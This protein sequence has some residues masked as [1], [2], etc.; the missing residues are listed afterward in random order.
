M[1]QILNNQIQCE[2]LVD[3]INNY[4]FLDDLKEAIDEYMFDNKQRTI[5]NG[6]PIDVFYVS[7]LAEHHHDALADYLNST[8]LK[9]TNNRTEL[10]EGCFA[11]FPVQHYWLKL[12]DIIIDITIKQFSDKHIDLSDKLKQLLDHQYFICDNPA[13]LFYQLYKY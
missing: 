7:G 5:I 3:V 9:P 11:D 4:A 10:S 1:L 8:V 13:N 6:E 12:G 2:P